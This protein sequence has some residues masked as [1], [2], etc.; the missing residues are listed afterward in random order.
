MKPALLAYNLLLNTVGLASLPVL[1]MKTRDDPEFTLGRMGHA[2]PG[3]DAEG[4]PRI[5]LH[6]VSVGEVTGAVPTLAVLRE[7]L[8]EAALTLTVG[9]PAGY[10][11]ARGQAGA[12]AR[13]IP[14]PL[15]FPRALRRVFDRLRPDLFVA[16]ES[17][18]WPNLF[19]L[20]R[21]EGVPALL[22]NGRLTARS[23]P[24]Y[25]KLGALFRPV[26]SQF[27]RLAM[28][29]EDDLRNILSVGAP[30]ERTF[31]LGTSKYDGILRKASPDKALKWRELLKVPTGVPVVV[32]GSLRQ[33]ECTDLIDAY[34]AVRE[35]RPETLAVFAPRHL[36]RVPEMEAH[37]RARGIPYQLLTRIEAGAEERTEP[38]VLVDRIGVLFELYSVG[39][40]VF[41][42]GTLE[43]VG[44]HN[45]LEPA[46]WDKPVF[47]GP[48]LQNVREEHTILRSFAGSF[49][50]ADARQLTAEWCRWI[51]RLPDLAV[52]GRGAGE[53][54]RKLGGVAERQVEIILEVLGARRPDSPIS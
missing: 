50:V 46:A 18:F 19:R 45:I 29:S 11:F 54:L 25:R 33:S 32:G 53:A 16:F 7:R 23:A 26:F 44:G 9:T 2:V 34:I 37:M 35:V 31:V 41:C 21:A 47:H 48:S 10:R 51:Q 36:H 15:D 24:R 5:W 39:D 1:R 8:P 52:H 43:P 30:P 49:L 4:S 14:F 22:L 13:V 3:E 27:E 17:E 6:A 20:L 42:G 12:M 38:V 40:L 28:H